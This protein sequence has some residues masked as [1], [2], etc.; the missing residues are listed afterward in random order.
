MLI[1]CYYIFMTFRGE[2]KETL[3]KYKAWNRY[4]NL[5]KNILS[6]GIALSSIFGLMAIYNYEQNAIPQT[7][8][9]D[10]IHGASSINN[11]KDQATLEADQ[12]NIDKNSSAVNLDLMIAGAGLVIAVSGSALGELR[13]ITR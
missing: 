5:S 1:L 11:P 7:E 3:D 12:K 8:I 13:R 6:G 10:I 4:D 2:I 9:N